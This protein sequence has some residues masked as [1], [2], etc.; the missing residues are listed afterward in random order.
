MFGFNFGAMT[1]EARNV[2]EAAAMYWYFAHDYLIR[3][4]E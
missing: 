4:N 3:Q 2:I 1:V